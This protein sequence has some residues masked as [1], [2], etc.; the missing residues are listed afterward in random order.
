MSIIENKT[1]LPK[2]EIKAI[3][4]KIITMANINVVPVA[5]FRKYSKKAKEISPDP[6]DTVYFALALKLN[7]PIW[8]NDLQ[9]KKQDSIKVYTTEEIIKIK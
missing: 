7:C 1:G 5:D 9:L 2:D 8:S 4:K 3:L 6:D